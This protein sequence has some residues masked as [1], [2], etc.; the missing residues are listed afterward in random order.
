LSPN[1]EAL[2][3][4]LQNQPVP[5]LNFDTDM[6][7]ALDRFKLRKLNKLCNTVNPV[8]IKTASDA[9]DMEEVMRLMRI[10]E[11]L[12]STRNELAKKTGTIVLP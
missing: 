9:G 4:P 11:K 1:W 8:R 7:Q 10:Q 6:R 3:F 12:K 5:D 2:G